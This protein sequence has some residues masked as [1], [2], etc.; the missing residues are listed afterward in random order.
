MPNAL[1]I[2]IPYNVFWTLNPRKIKPFFE[3][4]KIKRKMLDEQM[5]FMGAYVHNAVLS[6]VE[7]NLAGKKAKTNY[8]EKPFMQEETETKAENKTDKS[9]EEN[10]KKVKQIFQSLEIMKAN[11]E[12]SKQG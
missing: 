10:M 11:F 12:L 6:A 8:L 3:A 9:K 2:G 5:W 1:A 7:K 4:Y